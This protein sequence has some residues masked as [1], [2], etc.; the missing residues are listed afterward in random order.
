LSLCLS[1]ARLS[2]AATQLNVSMH[3]IR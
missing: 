2:G 1:I 3:G